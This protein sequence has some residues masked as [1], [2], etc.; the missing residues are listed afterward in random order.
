MKLK[1]KVKFDK[2]KY[3]RENWPKTIPVVSRLLKLIKPKKTVDF[4]P[5]LIKLFTI[6]N[7]IRIDTEHF[8]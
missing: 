1:F 7:P 2:P 4:H 5:R 6:A 3:Y 8:T